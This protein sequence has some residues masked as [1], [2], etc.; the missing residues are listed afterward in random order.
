MSIHAPQ[1]TEKR[2]YQPGMAAG[3]AGTESTAASAVAPSADAGG[4][5]RRARSQTA[6]SQRA[7]AAT[8]GKRREESRTPRILNAAAPRKALSPE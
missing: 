6:G 1:V 2:A 3:Y 8:R 7:N 5:C 4:R